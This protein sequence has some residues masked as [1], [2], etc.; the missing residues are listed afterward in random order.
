M[1]GV[2]MKEITK[3]WLNMANVEYKN[4]KNLATL[5]RAIAKN[6]INNSTYNIEAEG[7]DA[8]RFSIDIPTMPATNQKQSGRCWIFAGLNF[9]RE[10]IGQKYNIE[11]F[12]F[13]QNYV[14]FYDKLEKINFILEKSIELRNKDEDDRVLVWL[15]QTGI[16]DGGQWDMFVNVVEKYGL[17]SKDAMPE[18]NA[19][20]GTRQMNYLINS[21]LRKFN[22]DI[23]KVKDEDKVRDIKDKVMVDAYNLLCTCFGVPPTKFDFEYVD[24]KKEYHTIKDILPLEFYKNYVGDVLKDYVSIINAPTKDKPFNKSYTVDY[25]GNVIDGKDILYLNLNMD[26]F[27]ELVLNQLK[28]KELVWF[29]SDCSNY[30]DR[31]KGNWDDKLFTYNE[32]FEI[33]FNLTKEESLL[34]RHSA[35]NHAMV[36]TGVNIVED[37]PTKWKIENSWG[38]DVANKGY[39]MCSD[40]WFDRFVYQAVVNK[41]YLSA[42]QKKMLKSKQI[43]LKPWD[44]MGTLAD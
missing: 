9:L 31:T 18:T 21:M 20:S 19:S 39:Y 29:G 5:R 36:L 13:S 6:D 1:W 7:S 17:V 37:K 23:R 24:K 12:E 38:S 40:T 41:K 2:F 16:A 28:N 35:M 32:S 3:E 10:I 30:G 42:E 8:F 25:L 34:F 33:D 27:K 43:H 4:N 22:A 26:D 15:L 44:P 14:A 11:N